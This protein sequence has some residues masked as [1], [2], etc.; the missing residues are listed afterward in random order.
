MN[1]LTTKIFTLILINCGYSN[2][3]IKIE[4]LPNSPVMYKKPKNSSNN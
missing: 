4:L 3:N 2:Q 1:I